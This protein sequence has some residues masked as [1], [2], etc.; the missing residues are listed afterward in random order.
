MKF[1][2]IGAGAIGGFVGARLALAGE[3]VTFIARGRNLEAIGGGGMRVL[4]SAGREV[5]AASVRATD[6]YDRAGK[7]DVV[8]LTLKAH[9]LAAVAP[10]IESLCHDETIVVPMQNGIPF[11]YFHGHGGAHA[12][13]AVETV[14]P[15]G[16]IR[17]AIPARRI[18]GCVVY[19]ASELR[20][21]GTVAHSA[22]AR[23]QLGELDGSKSERLARLADAFTRASFTIEMPDDI[24]AAVW[25][26]LWGNVTFNPISALARA[27]MREICHDP[28]GTALAAQMMRE[29]QAVAE[30]LGITFAMT[31]EKRLEGAGRIGGHKTSMLQDVE[32]GRAIEIDALVGAV[33]E[34]GELAR[35]ATPAITAIY[36]AGKLLDATLR[37][38]PSA[39][40]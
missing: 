34:L 31:V 3:D 38:D 26:K 32:A 19:I 39:R 18:V 36:R 2:L 4:D 1:C 13:R 21:P 7:F 24:R 14:D 8:L 15:G 16:A 6:D 12:G 10:H 28:H 11:W 30:A 20:A 27:T 37:A 22:G 5:H 25:L 35:V 23:L 17:D 40:S 29:A 9:H 33:V